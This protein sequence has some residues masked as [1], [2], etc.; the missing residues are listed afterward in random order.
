[1]RNQT[2]YASGN[3]DIAYDIGGGEVDEVKPIYRFLTR[4]YLDSIF[5]RT[6]TR[7]VS[8]GSAMRSLS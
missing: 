4:T 3:R 7:E 5:A 2:W 8:H 1:M 6:C